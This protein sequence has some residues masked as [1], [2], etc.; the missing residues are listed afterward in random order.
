MERHSIDAEAAK[1]ARLF[2]HAGS[3]Q[4]APGTENRL[5]VRS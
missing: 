3:E 1:L 5:S 4:T 2:A